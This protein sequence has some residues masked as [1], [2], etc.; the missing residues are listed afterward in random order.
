MSPDDM[1]INS[2]RDEEPCLTVE[3]ELLK[4]KDKTIQLLANALKEAA[5]EL[6]EF[7]D[8]YVP[9]EHNDCIDEYRELADKYLDKKKPVRD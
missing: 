2:M 3:Q 5:N 4:S 7:E 9:H 1:P 8:I 6:Q